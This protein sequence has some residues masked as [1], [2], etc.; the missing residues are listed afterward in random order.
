VPRQL[1]L[2]VPEPAV[3]VVTVVLLSKVPAAVVAVKPAPTLIVYVF[4]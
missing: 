4:G 2:T 1:Q 3:N